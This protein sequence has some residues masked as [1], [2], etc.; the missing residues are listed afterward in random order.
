MSSVFLT[1]QWRNLLM[2]NYRIDPAVLKPFVPCRTEL[3]DFEGVHYVSLVGFLFK[4]VKLLGIAIPF[5]TTFEEV[6]LRFYVRFKEGTVWKRGVVF[7][8]E[9]VPRRAITFVANTLYNENY[10]THPMSHA[11]SF[12]KDAIHVAYQWKV[13][14]EWNYIK[15][16]AATAAAP[17]LKN[18][19]EEFITEHYWGYTLVSDRCTGVYQVKHP[20]WNIHAVNS[21]DI[22][23]N[24]A[25]LYGASFAEALHD[26]PQSVFL[27]DGS[28]VQ[29]YKG[30]KLIKQEA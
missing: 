6:N 23:C 10:A 1:A 17:A 4:D 11:W 5:H 15:A 28:A 16:T 18:S 9:I 29:V 25:R 3:D 12:E 14:T 8:K 20:R 13:G 22:K 7:L 27:A 2:A 24:A 30:S 19:A 21:Y 26:K